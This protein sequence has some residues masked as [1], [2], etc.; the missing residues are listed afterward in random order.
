MSQRFLE[1]LQLIQ[2]ADLDKTHMVS[3][4]ILENVL[5]T[6]IEGYRWWM[7]Q[8]LNPFIFLEGFVTDP[9]SFVDVT[10]FDTYGDFLNFIIR[11]EKMPKQYDE[12][13]EDARLAIKYNHTLNNVSVN[14]IPQQ[15]DELT[16]KESSFPLIGPFL[17]DKAPL[18]LGSTL[19]N[20]TE[21]MKHAIKNLIQKLKEV[22][23]FIQSEYM[24]HTRKT[25]G[26]LGWENGKQ[27]YI[28]S[29]RWHTSLNTTP[30]EV[31]QKGLD[32][33]KRIYDEMLKVMGKLG[34]H[35]SVRQFFDLMKSNSSFLI[36]SPVSDKCKPQI[37]PHP[38]Y[39]D[40]NSGRELASY[41]KT[42]LLKPKSRSEPQRPYQAA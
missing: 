9:Q 42:S 10:P 17:D 14:R 35:G 18:I 19:T 15:I 11:I 36:K 23:S 2:R 40:E 26:I 37:Q 16:S 33:V 21:R 27:N 31:H 20:M 39:R 29:L 1:Q 24:P 32:E 22:K 25:W 28:D 38:A 41:K 12:M 30:E 34:F 5:T 4:D 7:Y 3:Y 8:P 6:Y 13:I